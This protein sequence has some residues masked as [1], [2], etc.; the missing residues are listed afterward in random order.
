M[1]NWQVGFSIFGIVGVVSSIFGVVW[2]I[3][4]DCEAKYTESFETL[5]KTVWKRYDD[6][7]KTMKDEYLRSELFTV[8]ATNIKQNFGRIERTMEIM[9]EDSK[10]LEAKIDKIMMSMEIK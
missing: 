6:M 10:R 2:K 7:K 4:K 1:N 5:K 3:N 8:H 9:V